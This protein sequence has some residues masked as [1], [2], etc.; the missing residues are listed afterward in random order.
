MTDKG[1]LLSFRKRNSELARATVVNLINVERFYNLENLMKRRYEIAEGTRI[2]NLHETSKT[3]VQ[4][5]QKLMEKKR[6]LKYNN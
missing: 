5:P 6:Q 2:Y 3:M 1:W 4:K